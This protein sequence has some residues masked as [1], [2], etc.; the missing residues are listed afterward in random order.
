[1]KALQRVLRLF[2]FVGARA[3]LSFSFS[4]FFVTISARGDRKILVAVPRVLL[5]ARATGPLLAQRC[6]AVHLHVR[7]ARAQ[8]AR[9]R[10]RDHALFNLVAL[11]EQRA[12]AARIE[13]HE[14][15]GAEAVQDG[16][17]LHLGGLLRDH[18][19]AGR[20]TGVAKAVV[21]AR[22]RVHQALQATG[23][24]RIRH[25]FCGLDRG[26]GSFFF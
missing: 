23:L 21:N 11:A 7:E 3:S 17:G 15:R 5:H 1:M 13:V 20:G 12:D 19:Q 24:P 4:V 2:V 6:L 26:V 8:K 9:A 25:F 18:A 14:R 10:R 16:H 22:R